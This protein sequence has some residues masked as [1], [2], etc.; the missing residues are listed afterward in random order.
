MQTR[1]GSLHAMVNAEPPV[2]S[3][4]EELGAAEVDADRAPRWHVVTICRA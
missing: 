1:D 2:H 4:G 3:A